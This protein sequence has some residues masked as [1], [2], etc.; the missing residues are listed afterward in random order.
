MFVEQTI[1]G[2]LRY[3]AG[4]K[5]DTRRAPQPSAPRLALLWLGR[6][7]EIRPNEDG[8]DYEYHLPTQVGFP[9]RSTPQY[10]YYLLNTLNEA[11]S[12]PDTDTDHTHHVIGSAPDYAAD[13]L[14]ALAKVGIESKDRTAETSLL[15]DHKEGEPLEI[16]VMTLIDGVVKRC[17]AKIALNYLAYAVTAKLK[18]DPSW[19]MREEF[20]HVREFVLRGDTSPVPRIAVTKP[21]L[22]PVRGRQFPSGHG[23]ALAWHPRTRI[24]SAEVTLFSQFSW[25]IILG[26]I[27][28]APWWDIDSA[29][30]WV[31]EEKTVREMTRI[32]HIWLPW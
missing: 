30:F 29:H 10:Q 4:L 17:M 3:R 18:H 12:D 7:V 24:V 32:R 15:P 14:R 20:D 13:A 9:R 27:T 16:E 21:N 5:G 19:V 28:G 26:R 23:I 1:L 2:L 6:H 8:S 22:R 31:L 11:I 25:Q